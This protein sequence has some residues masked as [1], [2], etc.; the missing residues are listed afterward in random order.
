MKH[1][2]SRFFCGRLVRHATCGLIV[3]ALLAALAAP[4]DAQS[5]ESAEAPEVSHA[6]VVLTLKHISS[7]EANF[8]L[9][10]M[11][12]PELEAIEEFETTNQLIV[13]G[14]PAALERIS[15]LLKEIDIPGGSAEPEATT[16]IQVESYPVD[17][18]AG[19]VESAT[20]VP[21]RAG[22]RV[23]VDQI[24]RR[25][26]LT[27]SQ[28]AL[29]RARALVAQLDKPSGQLTL[30]FFFLQGEVG[31]TEGEATKL[32]DALKPIGATLEENGFSKLRLL[33]PVIIRA[34]E[35]QQFGQE[36]I[37]VSPRSTA[38]TPADEKPGQPTVTHGH[39]RANQMSFE[40]EGRAQMKEATDDVVLQLSAT[41]HGVA[42]S[43]SIGFRINTTINLVLDQYV[44]IAA[45]PSTTESGG[46]VA[47]AV[48]VTRA[49]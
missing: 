47:L 11:D 30:S 9:Q 37:L 4:T 40:L 34:N 25:L 2:A 24:N 32:P 21:G 38:P 36:S 16:L 12:I 3:T 19:L 28:L 13:V 18:L 33:A 29:E 5:Q 15:Q 43:N 41:L 49:E 45:A 10:R 48:R 31:V 35:G 46:A 23:G 20:S 7:S 22:P 1:Y 44:L 14:G 42:Q 27:G 26:V 8:L 6:P 17:K 39:N